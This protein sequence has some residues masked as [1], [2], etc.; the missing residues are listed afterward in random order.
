MA[1][2]FNIESLISTCFTSKNATTF[3]CLSLS[4]LRKNTSKICFVYSN[5]DRYYEAVTDNSSL[6]KSL[7]ND[8]KNIDEVYTFQH[9]T[10][11]KVLKW[12]IVTINLRILIILQIDFCYVKNTMFHKLNVDLF[13]DLVS[14]I[15]KHKRSTPHGML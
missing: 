10:G 11:I 6:Q 1:S 2:V 5:K 13:Y 9:H 15:R 3:G 14:N 8:I 7:F 4:I 12:N